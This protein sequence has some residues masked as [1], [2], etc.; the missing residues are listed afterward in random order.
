MK[1]SNEFKLVI[2]LMLERLSTRDDVAFAIPGHIVSPETVTAEETEALN[3]AGFQWKEYENWK[4][5]WLE[6]KNV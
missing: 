5:Y 4:G 6:I 2:E 3:A 1:L